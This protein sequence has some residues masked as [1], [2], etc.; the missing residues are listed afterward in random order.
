MLVS[1]LHFTCKAICFK[2]LETLLN[3]SLQGE[4]F[5]SSKRIG[6]NSSRLIYKHLEKHSLCGKC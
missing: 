2:N 1:V 5:S 6:Q 3:S 4:V